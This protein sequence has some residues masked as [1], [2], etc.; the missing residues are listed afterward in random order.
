MLDA[1]LYLTPGYLSRLLNFETEMAI[2]IVIL[3]FQ[4]N[5]YYS[6]VTINHK[7]GNQSYL[8][9]FGVLSSNPARWLPIIMWPLFMPRGFWISSLI[10]AIFILY[11]GFIIKHNPTK[12]LSQSRQPV[13]YVKLVVLI[14]TCQLPN[15]IGTFFWLIRSIENQYL[16]NYRAMYR[17]QF[18]FI[19]LNLNLL[20]VNIYLTSNGL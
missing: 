6:S 7:F 9:N 8:I 15:S 18:N 10:M 14:Q 1:K 5:W 2:L 20:V 19:H 17:N 13:W 12:L 11:I 4:I 3:A 16:Q